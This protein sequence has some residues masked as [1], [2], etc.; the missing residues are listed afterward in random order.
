MVVSRFSVFDQLSQF[1]RDEACKSALK[2]LRK[3]AGDEDVSSVDQV[4]EEPWTR[5]PRGRRS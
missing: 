2:E 3:R 1:S 5:R 4:A